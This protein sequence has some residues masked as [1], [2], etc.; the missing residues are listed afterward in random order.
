MKKS[1]HPKYRQIL[2]VDTA[3]G[4]KFICGSSVQTKEEETVDGVVY[5]VYRLSISAASH[6]LFTGDKRLVDAEGR[7]DKFKRRYAMKTSSAA[8]APALSVGAGTEASAGGSSVAPAAAPAAPVSP[9]SAKVQAVKQAKAG[10]AAG[11]SKAPAKAAAP[12]SKA[13]APA[14]KPAAGKSKK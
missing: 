5:P 13:A 6:P 8:D 10:A 3:T 9:A 11:A 2:F 12:A 7:V 1:G 14:G 4:T